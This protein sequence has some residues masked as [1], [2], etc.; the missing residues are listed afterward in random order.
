MS[1]D[2]LNVPVRIDPDGIYDDGQT[3]LLLGLTDATMRRARREGQ[4]RFTRQGRVLL[5]RG[6]WLLD[7]LEREAEGP[8]RD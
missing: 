5:Y 6:S 8:S 3:R 7:W 1:A 4:L 2:E